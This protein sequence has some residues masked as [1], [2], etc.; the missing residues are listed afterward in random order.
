MINFIRGDRSNEIVHCAVLWRIQL[1]DQLFDDIVVLA[2]HA[3]RDL[4][5]A[6]AG[7]GPGIHIAIVD[8]LLAQSDEQLRLDAVPA[9]GRT[10]TREFPGTAQ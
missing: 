1:V 5:G 8:D 10:H 4:E 2:S 9:Q 6:R 7:D 3:L